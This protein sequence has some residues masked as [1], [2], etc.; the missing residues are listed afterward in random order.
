M[1]K[2]SAL[3]FI[4]GEWPK[5]N[6]AQ[7]VRMDKEEV[8]VLLFPNCEVSSTTEFEDKTMGRD[9]FTG[10]KNL[11]RMAHFITKNGYYSYFPDTDVWN[12]YSYDFAC[13]NSRIWGTFEEDG[14]R[15]TVFDFARKNFGIE[16]T[17]PGSIENQL[18]YKKER[19]AIE[20]KEKRINAHIREICP[21]LP[22]GF[23]TWAKK[24]ADGSHIKLFQK[25]NCAGTIER[26]FTLENGKLTEIC[27]SECDGIGSFWRRWYYGE[28][29]GASGRKQ[30][31]WDRKTGLINNLPHKYLIY[32]NLDSLDM[33]ESWKS[34]VR[35][36]SG[37]ADPSFVI[38]AVDNVPEVEYVIKAGFK[39]FSAEIVIASDDLARHAIRMLKELPKRQQELVKKYDGGKWLVFILTLCPNLT[40]QNIKELS[41]IRGDSKQGRI[42]SIAE[43]GLN[44]NHI[45]TLLKKTG[46]INEENLLLYRDYLDMAEVKHEDIHDE[47]IYRNKKW[48]QYHDKYAEEVNR[49]RE[50]QRRKDRL[51]AAKKEARRFSGIKKDYSRNTKHFAWESRGYVMEVPKSYV[52]II[53]EGADQHHCVG[54]S[55][56]YMLS[57]AERKTFILFLRHKDTP[58]IPYYTIEAKWGGEICQAFSAYDRKP[59]WDEVNK[60]L[61][62]WSKE[63]R[64]KAS[65]EADLE[66]V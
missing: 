23:T 13:Y 44:M 30:S 6:H 59:E 11:G 45:L 54:A 2:K 10:M 49:I 51:A 14:F 37:I 50:E 28:N 1:K 4:K 64:K 18:K 65:I 58:D 42:Q 66:A 32:D 46:G 21:P 27:L 34:C 48:K 7:V 47:I 43:K 38:N 31:W 24:Q 61:Q 36:M 15:K 39:R 3:E 20:N 53:N 5:K 25:S 55:D 57:M 17:D 33:E 19:R 41:K 26:M 29:Y 16:T 8:L 52:D 56:R 35:I 63:V 40:E 9:H 60:V 62:E 12:R 22:A